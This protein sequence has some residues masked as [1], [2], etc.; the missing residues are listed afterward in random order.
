MTFSDAGKGVPGLSE[1]DGLHH[2]VAD[3]L[4]AH[5]TM[6][7][8][9]TG[10]VGDTP[11]AATVF[12]AVDGTLRLTFL[13]KTDSVHGSHIE[14]GTPV[15][16]TVTEV[17]AEWEKIQGV[18]LWGDAS[19]LS[20]GSKAAALAL[21]LAR[22]PFARDLLS[23]PIHADLMRDV[24]VYRVVPYRA[25]FTDNATGVFGREMLELET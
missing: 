21:Y 19:L 20:G 4:R 22:F 7:I 13:S 1:S 6:T 10:P 25:A 24:G 2:R 3:Y 14:E 12:Y 18:Q 23:Q 16:V 9:T 5:H 15:A 11:H 8:A 17:Y